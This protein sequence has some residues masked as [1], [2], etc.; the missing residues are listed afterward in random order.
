[1][2]VMVSASFLLFNDN[3]DS[4]NPNKITY[5]FSDES[6]SIWYKYNFTSSEFEEY[7]SGY[8]NT[9]QEVVNIPSSK[10]SN[11]S[12]NFRILNFKILINCDSSNNNISP[13]LSDIVLQY[14][15]KGSWILI[16]GDELYN[17]F[18]IENFPYET[19]VTN[20]G[21]SNYENLK[22]NIVADRL[23]D[24]ALDNFMEKDT[25]DIGEKGYVDKSGSL[26][27]GT[28]VEDISHEDVDNLMTDYNNHKTDTSKHFNINDTS[29]SSSTVYSSSKVEDRIDNHG[30]KIENLTDIDISGRENGEA[31]IWD[32]ST[33]TYIHGDAGKSNISEMDDVSITSISSGETLV[34]DEITSKFYNGE[35]GKSNI[36]EMDDVDLTDRVDGTTLVWDNDTSKYKHG[37]SSALEYVRLRKYAFTSTDVTNAQTDGYLDIDIIDDD[38]NILEISDN[39]N[40]NGIEI[41]IGR[42]HTFYG[43]VAS[44]DDWELQQGTASTGY[45]NIIRIHEDWV[46][47]GEIITGYVIKEKE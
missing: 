39:M 8:G 45:A 25:Y 22:I 2:V 17:N 18:K 42:L 9:S 19:K 12:S 34:W 29:S 31:I 35:G 14:V 26:T 28:T 6:K 1:S 15:K 36:S 27:N 38:S 33:S 47:E 5:L 10:F 20:V 37:I 3:Y 4:E 13:M 41:I 23:V 44:G 30:H 24:S 32:D 11:F 43:D 40:N 16:T 46:V 7:V 21:S